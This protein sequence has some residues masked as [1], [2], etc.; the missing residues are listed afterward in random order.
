MSDGPM[1][2]RLRVS[3]FVISERRDT[4][5]DGSQQET[6]PLEERTAITVPI[7]SLDFRVTPRFGVHASTAVPLLARTGTV[8]RPSGAAP[9]RD[10][11]RGLGDTIIGGWYRGGSPTK[12]S[13]TLNGGLSL[14]TGQTRAPRFRSELDDGSLVPLSR[15]QRGSGTVDPVVGVAA[16]HPVRGGRWL[17]S[18]AARVPLAENDD[19][20]RVGTSS[21][22]GTGWAHTVKTHRV[23]AFGRVDWLHRQQ[24]VFNGTPVLVGGGHWLYLTTGIAV[25]V[26]KG[27]NV[28]A[29][30]KLPAYRQLANRQLD[31]HAIWQVG[32]SRS[33]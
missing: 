7:V 20:L 32:V 31:S 2:G 1:I 6:N 33:F 10:D 27:V 29:D 17:T 26:G 14:P 19:G 8:Q 30:V 9:F 16:E 15:L 28:Q 4:V 24:D 12:W 25:M 18:F 5:Y 3:M 21:E 11:V 22:L 13:W 23:M